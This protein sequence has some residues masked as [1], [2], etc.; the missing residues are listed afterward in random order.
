MR[1]AQGGRIIDVESHIA[2]HGEYKGKLIHFGRPANARYMWVVDEDGDFIV[3]NKQV[4]HHDMPQ[5]TEEKIDSAHRKHK[6]PHATGAR[7]KMIFGAGEVLVEGG[8]VKRFNSATGHYVDLRNLS[9]FNQ[10]G[11]QVF[12]SFIKKT[13]W[14]E[15]DGGAQYKNKY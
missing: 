11:E 3:A 5:M 15:V 1:A 9:E 14:K 8:K 2:H 4:M 13:G 12:R 10:Q 6:L 7:G